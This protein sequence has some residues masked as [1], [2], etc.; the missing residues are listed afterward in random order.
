MKGKVA[1]TC[2]HKVM[3]LPGVQAVKLYIMFGPKRGS[4]ITMGNKCIIVHQC[5]GVGG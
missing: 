2:K 1:T 3:N 5:R 4:H